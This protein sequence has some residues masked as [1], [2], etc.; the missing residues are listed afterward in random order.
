MKLNKRESR[1]VHLQHLYWNAYVHVHSAWSMQFRKKKFL[2]TTHLFTESFFP[3]SL[4]PRLLKQTT[5]N[6]TM[7]KNRWANFE[8]PK[9]RKD[10]VKC[11]VWY[12]G[13][14]ESY[15]H[16]QSYSR[17]YWPVEAKEWPLGFLQKQGFEKAIKAGKREIKERRGRVGLIRRTESCRGWVLRLFVVI[18]NLWLQLC[19]LN[20]GQSARSNQHT[21]PQCRTKTWQCCKLEDN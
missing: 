8:F 6:I 10:E 18:I 13:I 15:I 2:L 3:L 17:W 1:P 16:M 12:G 7:L 20:I 21:V 14:V 5:R 19:L 4:A 11:A 9:S